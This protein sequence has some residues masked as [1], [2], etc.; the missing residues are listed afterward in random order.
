MIPLPDLIIGGVVL[1]VVLLLAVIRVKQ[2]APPAAQY[3][4]PTD[5]EI[6]LIAERIG[7]EWMLEDA[8]ELRRIEAGR[9]LRDAAHGNGWENED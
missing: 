6:D 5:A 1:C 4:P 2:K 8:E 7:Q 3:P 9:K